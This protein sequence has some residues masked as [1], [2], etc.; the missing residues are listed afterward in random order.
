MKKRLTFI[1]SLLAICVFA[2]QQYTLTNYTQEQGLPSGTIRGIYKDTTGY[3][4]LTSEGSLARFD[5][6]TFK[7]Y[8]YNP[9]VPTGLPSP[10]YWEAAFPKYGDIYF[11]DREHY[12]SFN[13]VTEK[14]SAPFGKSDEIISV[15]EA[16]GV[17]GWYWLR[18]KDAI[19][20]ISKTGTERFTLPSAWPLGTQMIPSPGNNCMFFNEGSNSLLFFDYQTK[21]FSIPKI[22]DSHGKKDSSSVAEVIFTGNHFYLFTA[23]HLFRFD[24]TSKSFVWILDLKRSRNFDYQFRPYLSLNDSLVVIRSKSCY[25]NI[26]NIRTGEEK[27]VCVNKKIPEAEMNDGFIL[28]CVADYKGGVW[29]GTNNMGLIYYNISTG[30]LEQYIHEPANSNSLPGNFITWVMPDENGVVWASCVGHGIVK[31]EPVSALFKTAVPIVSK[32]TNPMQGGAW[33]ESIRSFLGT[34]DGY[35]IGTMNGLFG[36]SNQTREFSNLSY[37]CPVSTPSNNV[38]DTE[39]T[40]AFP[41]GSLAEDRSGNLWIGTWFGELVVY[42][43]KLKKSFPFRRPQPL[44]DREKYGVFRNLYCDRNNRMWISTQKAGIAVVDCNTLNFENIN[45]STFV[46]NFPDTNNLLAL[47]PGI[48]FVVTEDADGIIWAGTENGLCRYNEQ[49]KKWKR[50]YNIPGDEKSI[51]NNNVRSLCLDQKGVLWIGTNGGGLNRYNKE[52]DNFTH[53]TIEDGLADDQIYTLVCD[54]NGMLWMGTNHGL[55]RFNPIDYSCKNFSKKDGIQNYEYNTGAALKLKDGTLLFGGVAGYNIIDPDI[56]ETK[57]A[58][59]PAVVISSFKVFDKETP[60]GNHIIT[61]KYKENTLTFE[62]AALSYFQNHDNH[63][64]YMLEGVDHDWIFSDTRRYVTYSKLAPGD[65]TFKVKASNS[66]GVWN[67][68]GAQLQ[69]TITPPWWQRTWFIILCVMVTIAILYFI[70]RYEQNRKKQLEAVRAR[71][72]RDLHDDM[73]STLQSISVMSEIARMKSQSGNQQES[74]PMIEK[75]GSASREMVEKM[76][77][78]VWAV[79]PKNDNFENIILHMRAFG[80]ELLAGKDIALH[81]KADSDL[82]NIRLSMEKRKSFFLVYKE[83]LNNAY[84]YSGAKNVNVEIS[85]THHTLTLVVEDDGVGFNMHEDRLKTGGN[86]LKNM[87]SRAAELNGNVSITSAPGRG[88]KVSLAANLGN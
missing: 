65:Y 49:T 18:S 26:L 42:N 59:P 23:Q 4:W 56:I 27:L 47:S 74:I 37:L 21:Q 84:K 41:V 16:K 88:T 68:T 53:F 86:G 73:G 20:R 45:A 30:H 71:I 32:K 75:I 52:E 5:G 8:R 22:L 28:T 43:P 25:I 12:I 2:Q 63:Y 80:G 76:N 46:Y 13:P 7:T 87:N 24:P 19:Y 40:K 14:F 11:G 55:C 57:K 81:F 66:D 33:S 9:D 70:R 34:E 48:S 15:N 58:A 83:A 54:N 60:I 3:I 79:N 51:H 29:I 17:K 77:D 35:W 10:G 39:F 31:M 67:E 72:S 50:Y 61:L 36:Y 78:I 64:A 38:Y 6:Y 69:M 85:R 44:K 1:F 82:N 62:F